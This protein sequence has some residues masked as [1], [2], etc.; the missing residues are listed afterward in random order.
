MS[1]RGRSVISHRQAVWL[2]A[3]VSTASMAACGDAGTVADG[4][5]ATGGGPEPTVTSRA[6]RT[7]IKRWGGHGT[8]IARPSERLSNL[9][10]HESF[11]V[12]YPTRTSFSVAVEPT[13][14]AAQALQTDTQGAVVDIQFAGESVADEAPAEMKDAAAATVHRLGNVVVLYRNPRHDDDPGILRCL[15]STQ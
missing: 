4:R 10:A 7:C 6:L 14:A 12:A 5:T 15:G 13:R 3:L 11:D 1:R 2:V 9:G 8:T